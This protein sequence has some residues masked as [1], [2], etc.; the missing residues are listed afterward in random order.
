MARRRVAAGI[1]ATRPSAR[2]RQWRATG[3][4]RQ[5]GASGVQTIAPRSMS[6]WLN[7]PGF[8]AGTSSAAIRQIGSSPPAPSS[9][10]AWPASRAI[11]R[12]ELASTIGS[13]R[14]SAIDAIAPAV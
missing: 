4:V 5:S 13:R 11:T 10:P 8:R 3:Q 1:S 7:R 2:A 14:P 9:R 6:A 12:R